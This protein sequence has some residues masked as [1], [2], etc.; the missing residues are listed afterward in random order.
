MKFVHISDTH[1]GYHQYGLQERAEDFYDVFD[2]AVDFAI[3]KKVDFVIHTGDFFHSSRP[4]NQVILQGISILQKL[5]DAGIPIFVISGNHDRGSQVR[6][7]SPLKILEPS[8]LKLIDNGVIEY[9]G[10]FFAGLKYI[11][12]AGLKQI[13]GSLRPIFEK[14]LKNMG[15][16][17]KILMLHQEFQP[18]FP[19]SN[20]YLKNE[21]PEGFDY[22]GIG[23]YHIPQMPAVINGATVVQPGSTEFTAYNEK[24]EEAGKGFYY[25]EVDG[26]EVKPQFIKL[27]R[28]RPFLYYRFSEENIEE[29]IKQIKEDIEKLGGGK[30][31]VI[32]FKG[33]L[34]ELTY[35]DIY[36][37]LSAEGISEEEG[38]ILHLHFN[39]TREVAEEEGFS[40]IE[41]STEKINQELKRLIEDDELF[42]SVVETLN[43]LRTFDNIDEI[44]KYLKENPDAIDI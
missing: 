2:E 30:K 42:E 37:Y 12:K 33:V 31:P 4:S 39:L 44:K 20:L 28:R 36:K 23:H 26:K 19:S 14:Y 21:I 10:I 8:G 16:G 13:G 32:V 5:K 35:K 40:V 22:V 7:V 27:N 1:L 17:F 9:D 29:L 3:E 11:S 24:E 25:V 34:K 15:N 43:F 38:S 18:F 6:D 41:T